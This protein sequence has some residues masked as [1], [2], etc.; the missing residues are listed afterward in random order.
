MKTLT[1]I[2]IKPNDRS[3]ETVEIQSNGDD[4]QDIRKLLECEYIDRANVGYYELLW[5]DDEGLLTNPNPNGYFQLLNDAGLPVRTFA[6]NGL[7]LGTD[8]AGNSVSTK[9]S[10]EVVRQHVAFI[11]HADIDPDDIEPK[12]T[13]TTW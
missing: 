8:P 13:V 12:F 2:L 4:W 6:G 1:A 10:L 9:L 3:I 5:V 11:E 7:L